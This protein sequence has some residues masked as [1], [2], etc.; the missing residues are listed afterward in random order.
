MVSQIPY[1][2]QIFQTYS[3]ELQ[4]RCH[5]RMHHTSP[6]QEQLGADKL[7]VRI[8]AKMY[9]L[10]MSLHPML[11]SRE[12]SLD[13]RTVLHPS[14]HS[15]K[16]LLHVSQALS[17]PCLRFFCLPKT[18]CLHLSLASSLQIQTLQQWR[19]QHRTQHSEST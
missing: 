13:I 11:H 9:P 14:P 1:L 18:I 6:E 4:Y 8:E 2:R 5:H 10:L 12:W 16:V 7:L 15:L 3:Q 17:R 19:Q